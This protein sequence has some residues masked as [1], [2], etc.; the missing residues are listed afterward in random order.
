[1]AVWTRDAVVGILIASLV[2]SAWLI[3]ANAKEL[4]ARQTRTVLFVIPLVAAV[5]NFINQA[6]FLVQMVVP[7]SHIMAGSCY[8][9][10][11]VADLAYSLFQLGATGVLAFRATSL[12]S[13]RNGSWW[14]SR[15]GVRLALFA[16]FLSGYVLVEYSI[17]VRTI[18]IDPVRDVCVAIYDRTTNSAGKVIYL[19]LY[20][21]LG[22]TFTAPLVRHMSATA[23]PLRQGTAGALTG[24]ATANN[25]DRAGTETT[26]S[27]TVTLS[28][29]GKPTATAIP[30]RRA[31]SLSLALR[32]PPIL[33]PRAVAAQHP[34]LFAVLRGVGFR[35]VLAVLGYLITSAVS[36]AGG[37]EDGFYVEFT[38]Q[39]L[40]AMY[41]ATMAVRSRKFDSKR[42][43][44]G[45][46]GGGG[47]GSGTGS[48]TSGGSSGGPSTLPRKGAAGLAT[49]A[50]ATVGRITPNV[51]ASML[52]NE[53]T[54]TR[55]N[56][57]I[58]AGKSSEALA[59]IRI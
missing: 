16:L 21:I 31:T 27:A 55:G 24:A 26:M 8:V 9:W 33:V 43:S 7:A 6:L 28:L 46:G 30:S 4:C 57:K 3:Y 50:S 15:R 19:V 52:D 13:A 23:N 58:T 47:A 51:S 32:I 11:P 29:S 48:R 17:I 34:Q 39:N 44:S 45:G 1:M 18:A 14:Q 54:M 49:A 40:S 42:E 56:S 20:A 59:C 35:I 36:Y 25:G 5:C 12:V 22:V 38:C 41:A 10:V 2:P 53:A 37:F